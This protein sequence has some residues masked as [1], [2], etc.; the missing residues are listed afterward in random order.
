MDRELTKNRK[1]PIVFIDLLLILLNL[2]NSYSIIPYL[3]FFQHSRTVNTFIIFFINVVY[4]LIR[5]SRNFSLP[6]GNSL[7]I[8]YIII[9]LFNVLISV[10]TNMG[11]FSAGMYFLSNTTF[12]F[13]L[14]NCY[15]YYCSFFDKSKSFFL[16]IKPYLWLCL[17]SIVGI[18]ILHCLISMGINPY[19]NN[20]DTRMDL[21]AD[22]I[23][24]SNASYYF[25]YFSILYESRDIRIPFFQSKGFLCGIYHEPHILTF[26]LFPAFFIFWNQ[27]RNLIQKILVFSAYIFIALIAGSTT[28]II[29]FL[30]CIIVWMGVKMRKNIIIPVIVVGLIVGVFF[31]VDVSYYL[32][33][34][35]KFQSGSKDYSLK[36][37]SF[38]FT[39]KTLFGSNILNT[40]YV[41]S[42]TSKRDIGF[43]MFFL[44]I[45]FL[46]VFAIKTIKLILSKQPFIQL[47]GMS[48]LYFFLHSMKVTM[49][50]YSLSFLVFFIFILTVCPKIR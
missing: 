38:A 35:D 36:M 4:I 15:Q 1:K 25:P 43:I 17:L 44:N 9:T 33:I 29:A 30:F 22:N 18:L 12:F 47:L 27:T 37:I 48:A 2:A 49:V 46:I 28:N 32:F 6:K 3:L 21:F 13:I 41:L 5:F 20:V 8:I 23:E 19:I 7:F 16:V 45:T 50:A 10:Y 39:P 42:I 40:D 26:M 31:F 11:Y 34:L 14:Y 24:V